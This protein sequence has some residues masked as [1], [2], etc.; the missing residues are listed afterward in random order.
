[1]RRG[2][3]PNE[4]YNAK[5]PTDGFRTITIEEL[6]HHSAE[7]RFVKIARGG[8]VNLTFFGQLVE[9][10]APELFL[11]QDEQCEVIISRRTF[12]QVTVIYPITGG[13]ASC[14]ATLKPQ[15]AWL[16]ENRDELRAAMRCKAAV[17]RA[18]RQGVKASKVAI[19]AANPVALLEQQKALPA[20]DIIGPQKFFDAPALEPQHPEMCSVEYM[21]TRHKRAGY[22]QSL[23]S[24]E[25]AREMDRWRR[26]MLETRE[27]VR[28]DLR[29]YMSRTQMSLPEIAARVGYQTQTMQQFVSRARFGTSVETG[30]TVQR[31]AAF[32]AENP[33][34][35]PSFPGRIYETEGTRAM[36]ELIADAR[37]GIWGTCYA[38]YGA[39][40]TFLF[41]TVFAE[42]AR[43]AIPWF[44]LVEAVERMSPRM[45]LAAI[46]RAIAAPYA[47]Y[48]TPLRD[49]VL[50]ELRRRK[51]L[52]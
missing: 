19:A 8:Q 6:D 24:Q 5:R 40:K 15:L 27:Q 7:H 17:H 48:T 31:I 38:P 22:S 43:E 26:K 9:Y 23:T 50:G 44:A 41:Q 30:E 21:A 47:Q 49:A 14:V 52:W 1:M 3:T 29:V 35:L 18:I 39:Q 16:P 4:A 45:L 51:C 10:I 25:V 33:P 11:H 20:K 13:T 42:S 32:M 2:M 36:R 34:E 46:A 37:E 28:A 12:R